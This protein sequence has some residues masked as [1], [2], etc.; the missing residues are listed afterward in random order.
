MAL[1][2][3]VPT[4]PQADER[5]QKNSLAEVFSKLEI[6]AA[7]GVYLDERVVNDLP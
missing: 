6:L 3:Q 5:R 7:L 4:P 1:G 2:R